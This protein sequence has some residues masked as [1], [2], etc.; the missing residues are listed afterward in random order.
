MAL[1]PSKY[2]SLTDLVN[3]WSDQS[4][5]LPL[6]TLQRIC[7]WAV[8]GRFPDRTFVKANGREIDLLELHWAMR[9][10]IGVHAPITRDESAR[11][12]EDALVSKA[13]I[14]SFCD[15]LRIKP[16]PGTVALRS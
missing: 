13:G 1:A 6:L 5:E 12:L 2:V 16:P 8:C 7:D 15:D 4:G 9:R 3:D 10:Q 11:L 14:E